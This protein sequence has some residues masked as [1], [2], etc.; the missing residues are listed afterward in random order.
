MVIASVVVVVV[1]DY[2]E[3]L[4]VVLCGRHVEEM[5]VGAAVAA[6]IAEDDGASLSALAGLRRASAVHRAA[7]NS[8]VVAAVE[9]FPHNTMAFAS[10]DRLLDTAFHGTDHDYPLLAVAVVPAPLSLLALRYSINSEYAKCLP[11]VPMLSW[12]QP[13]A[14]LH[15][16]KLRPVCRRRKRRHVNAFDPADHHRHHF[17]D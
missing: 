17:S 15:S 8:L 6:W 12:S 9:L 13:S 7:D 3:H 2:Y 5:P 14:G 11:E 10:A 4:L 16:K 1:V